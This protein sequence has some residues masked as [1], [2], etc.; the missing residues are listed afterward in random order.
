MGRL[1]APPARSGEDVIVSLRQ[2]LRNY[3]GESERAASTLVELVQIRRRLHH[4]HHL[5]ALDRA[6]Y[7]AIFRDAQRVLAHRLDQV[8]KEK[9]WS[10]LIRSWNVALV[11]AAEKAD[12]EADYRA[13]FAAYAEEE[14]EE[15]REFGRAAFEAAAA[16]W[17]EA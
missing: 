1:P 12:R 7:E 3:F 15:H 10:V 14:P 5:D 17:R 16:R 4:T 6:H 2:R 13:A 8:E 9:R 11:E